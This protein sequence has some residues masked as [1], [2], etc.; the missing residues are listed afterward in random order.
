MKFIAGT[1]REQVKHADTFDANN[2]LTR[3][4]EIAVEVDESKAVHAELNPG[5]ASLHHVLLFHGSEPN[6]SGRPDYASGSRCA[7]SRPT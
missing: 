7:T 4:Q 5:Q 2:L 3:G 1:H 6:L